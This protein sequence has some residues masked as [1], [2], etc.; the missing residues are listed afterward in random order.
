MKDQRTPARFIREDVFRCPNQREFGELLG[1]EQGTISRFESGARQLNREAQDRIRA[2]AKR[3]RIKWNDGWFF[4]V[5]SE[6]RKVA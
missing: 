3:K 2:A 5:P 1:Y 6:A 4:E